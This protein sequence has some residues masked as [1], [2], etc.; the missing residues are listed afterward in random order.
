MTI[1][2]DSGGL[3]RPRFGGMPTGRFAGARRPPRFQPRSIVESDVSYR[4]HQAETSKKSA[5]R[6]VADFVQL[7]GKQNAYRAWTFTSWTNVSGSTSRNGMVRLCSCPTSH[8]S[9]KRGAK[10]SWAAK[11]AL[12]APRKTRC[13]RGTTASPMN[14]QLPCGILQRVAADTTLAAVL[15]P[16]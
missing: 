9:W 12:K 7:L 5:I 11:A 14:S 6:Q 1:S 10:A 8:G 15:A 2:P 13:A 4:R 3:I 16:L